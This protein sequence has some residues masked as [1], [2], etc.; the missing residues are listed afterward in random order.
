MIE[1]PEILSLFGEKSAKEAWEPVL[2]QFPGQILT[3]ADCDR[4]IKAAMI[5]RLNFI[6]NI[7][8]VAAD[9]YSNCGAEL[10]KHL[11]DNF[12]QAEVLVL[13]S[14]DTPSIPLWSLIADKVRHL[15]VVD[16][17]KE[18]KKF[19]LLL[20]TMAANKPW[21]LMAYLSADADLREFQ[22]FESSQKESA[23]NQIESLVVGQSPDLDI[24][25]QKAILLADE[26]IE[27]AIEAAPGAT[28]A[29][30]GI[31]VRAGFDGEQFALQVI[32]N[33]GRLTPE[34]ALEHMARHQD[35]SISTDDTRGRGLFILWQFFDH[36]HVNVSLGEQTAVGGQISR[37]SSSIEGRAR[38][39]NFFQTPSSVRPHASNQYRFGRRT[40]TYA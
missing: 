11:H 21:D 24:L 18:C 34:K 10:I 1:T 38:G 23:I 27:N 25:R 39:F 5:S 32:D 30:D 2:A 35:G 20:E 14:T 8:L 9:L 19:Q 29:Q 31:I 7:I 4:P 40:L 17:I 15:A 16:P 28:L 6:P 22:L 12:P 36:F 26:M 37:Q 13:A 33:W 3:L